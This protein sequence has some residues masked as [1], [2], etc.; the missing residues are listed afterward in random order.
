MFESALAYPCAVS[1]HSDDGVR[2]AIRWAA[3]RIAVGQH[4]TVWVLQKS[5]LTDNDIAHRLAATPSVQTVVARGSGYFSANGPV[6]ALFANA[7]D[8]GKITRA[9]GITA[10][11]VVTWSDELRTWA[12]EVKAE[13]LHELE[14]DE[15]YRALYGFEEPVELLPEI[16][17]AMESITKVINHN[18]TIKGGFEK[19]QVVRHLLRLHDAGIPLP[20]QEMKEWAA[21]HGWRGDNPRHLAGYA[22]QINLGGRPRT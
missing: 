2:A 4:L 17:A 3:D 16:V 18:N 13:V 19:R 15:D 11:C 5:V 7:D 8:L 21:A 12:R 14:L 9:H 6:L 1:D 20:A 22:D 10:L